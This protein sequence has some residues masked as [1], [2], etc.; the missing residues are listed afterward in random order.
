M[1]SL[2]IE[3]KVFRADNGTILPHYP[4][5]KY[6][7]TGLNNR[8]YVQHQIMYNG[9]QLL[10]CVLDCVGNIIMSSYETAEQALQALEERLN[11]EYGFISPTAN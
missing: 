7:V 3:P 8:D 6:D 9:K 2:G 1:F 5:F 11:K 10:W 4:I